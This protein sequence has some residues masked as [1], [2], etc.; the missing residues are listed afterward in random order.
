MNEGINLLES[1]KKTN[2]VIPL[3]HLQTM[4]IIVVGLLFIVSVSS[5]I[6]FILVTISPL[7]TLQKQE[8][9]LEQSV[10]LSKDYIVKLALVK[11]RT[12]AIAQ[13]LAN[14]QDFDQTLEIL[15]SK[16]TGDATI[17]AIQATNTGM[18]VTAESSSLQDVDNFL[19]GLIA[20]VQQKKDFSQVTLINLTN[21]QVNN[22]YEVVVR[23]KPL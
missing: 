17:I 11:E 14:R 13:F 10:T 20:L 3:K 22:K 16:L 7:P 1:N 2:S 6:L 9:S 21:D 4:R 23:V 12:K 8:Q 19:N 15:E 18:T 5:V